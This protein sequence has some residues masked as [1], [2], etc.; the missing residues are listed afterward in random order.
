MKR[1]TTKAAYDYS[2]CT[3]CHTCTYVCPF[4]VVTNPVDRPLEKD[5]T[6]P[7]SNECL[8]FNDVE[9]FIDLAGEGKFF[10]AWKLIKQNNPFPSIT[11][12]VCYAHCEAGCNRGGFDEPIAISTIERFLGDMAYQRGWKLPIPETHKEERVAII[13]SGPAG[14]SCAYHLSLLGYRPVVF[15]ERQAAGGMLRVGI[16]E[17]RLPIAILDR[18]IQDIEEMGIE[19]QL[20]RKMGRDFSFEDLQKKYD[21]LF[22]AIGSPQSRPLN[23]PG[24]NL[25]QV[26]HGLAFLE[27][28]K[29]GRAPAIGPRVAVIGGGNT[30]IDAARSALRL[31]AEVTLIYRRS[32]EE[33]P[34]NSEEVIA[35]EQEGVRINFLQTPVGFAPRNGGVV[36]RGVRMQLGEQDETGRRRPSQVPGSDFDMEFDHVILAIGE[37]PDAA[38]V[39]KEISD[40]D[41]K[42][43]ADNRGLTGI[44]KVFSGGDVVTGPAFVSKAIGMGK[45]AA[46]SV[47]DHLQKGYPRTDRNIKVILLKDMNIDYFDRQ[48]RA[49]VPHLSWSDARKSFTEVKGGLSEQLV[50]TEASRCLHCAVPPVYDEKRCLGC[51]NCEQRCPHQAITMVRRDEPFVVGVDMA[52]VDAGRVRELCRKARFNPEQI[53]CYCTETRAEEIAAAILKG[54]DSPAAIGAMTG[55]GSG[56]SVECIQPMLRFLE[57]AGIAVIPPKGTQWYGR[58]TTAWEIS[59]KITEK[60]SY[61][62]FHF[63]DDLN[64]LNRVVEKEERRKP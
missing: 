30:A 44:K 29:C 18:E 58:T 43:K 20:G 37:G 27:E 13:G 52:T 22:V 36:M 45:R 12:R 38:V 40:S 8:A 34:A 9:G 2:K 28:V 21:A 14:L 25:P 26:L 63:K 32:R 23:V 15:D 54:A 17:Y 56:C 42:V 62:K 53:V 61:Q 51:S 39:P 16:P 49:P 60:P 48:S 50:L 5:Q 33:M 35:A 6:P 7:C 4:F 3:G 19:I 59:K 46:Q 41:G 55:A 31:G 11:G 10:E 57:A 1:V 47:E 24:E 64:L